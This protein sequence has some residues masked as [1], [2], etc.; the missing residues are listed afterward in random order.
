MRAAFAGLGLTA[1]ATAGA[2]ES[3][4]PISVSLVECGAIFDEVA[5]LGDRKGRKASDV[6]K[7]RRT[8]SLFRDEAAAQAQAEG[9]AD[10]GGHVITHSTAMAD[11]WQ[12]RFGSVMLFAENKDWIDYCEALG[13]DRGLLPL[14]D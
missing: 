3:V 1:L 4:Q 9:I 6:D 13:T 11:K 8:A 2:A 12:G 7:L 5:D 10:T 14:R